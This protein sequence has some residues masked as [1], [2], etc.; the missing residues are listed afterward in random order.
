MEMRNKG[1]TIL[2]LMAVLPAMPGTAGAAALWA[3][4]GVSLATAFLVLADVK[5]RVH[6]SS[7]M[8][9]MEVI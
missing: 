7:L 6:Q 9:L 4:A 8:G 1:W 5:R 3:L 2:P